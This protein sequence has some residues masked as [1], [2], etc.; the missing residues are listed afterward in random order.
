MSIR[1]FVSSTFSDLANY[2]EV[3]QK[4]IRQFGAIDISM[5]NFGAR[6]K[7]PK[8]ECLRIISEE[9]DFFVGIYAH[10]YGYIPEGD[11]LSITEAEY[12]AASKKGIHRLIYLLNETTPWI[13]DYI[14][15]GIGEEKLHKFKDR[16]KT[17][18]ICNFFSNEFE[19]AAKV[20]ADLGRTLIRE[21]TFPQSLDEIKDIAES[22]RLK[23]SELLTKGHYYRKLEDYENAI[24][25]YIK[26][27]KVDPTFHDAYYWLGNSYYHTGEYSKAVQMYE[28]ALS[29]SNNY[30]SAYDGLGN[31][32]YEVKVNDK[33]LENF[34]KA[35]NVSPDYAN[36]YDGLGSVYYRLGNFEEAILAWEECI[37]LDPF[38]Q[39]ALKWLPKARKKLKNIND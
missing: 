33:A 15:K 19:L 34:K 31:V 29:I 37:R 24:S 13:P 25:Y 7:R 23:A 28:K 35:I 1:V 30:A 11:N 9:C 32:Y 14:E 18:H 22:D 10:K 21:K 27:L 2:R 8:E 26:S 4:V 5:E 36:A 12:D 6:D 39:N 38:K 3:V 20:V 16:L 17:K